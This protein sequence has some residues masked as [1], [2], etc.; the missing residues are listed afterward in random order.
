MMD[1]DGTTVVSEF[2]AVP[3]TR[4]VD[5]V[6]KAKEKLHVGMATGRT[7]HEAKEIAARLGLV[8]PSVV[9]GGAQIV[10]IKSGKSLWE[11]RLDAAIVLQIKSIFKKKNIPLYHNDEKI[12]ED[13]LVDDSYI[14]KNPF[15]LWNPSLEEPVAD[16]LVDALSKIP[17]ISA[18]KIHSWNVDRYTVQITHAQA[19]KQHGIF[20]VAKI[21]GIETHE[22]IGV[23]D[24]YNDFPLLLACGL[25]IAMG[26]APQ[27][28]KD[29]ADFVAPPVTE[30]GL[31]VVIEKFILEK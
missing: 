17:S 14:P 18:H 27:E 20:E 22:M 12:G 30:D 26:N 6:T 28:L 31:A 13:H 9:A 15:A 1:I 3:S 16:I 5:A 2:D 4:V 29:I 25:K 11:Q 10:D 24:S 19:T 23:G 7:Y 21:L 8:G